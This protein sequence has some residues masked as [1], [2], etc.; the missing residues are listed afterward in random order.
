[1]QL[2]S[3]HNQQNTLKLVSPAAASPDDK[4]P[5]PQNSE[6]ITS[7]TNSPPQRTDGESKALTEADDE[8]GIKIPGIITSIYSYDFLFNFYQI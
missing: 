7:L 4:N 5:R 2:Q 3:S 8:N 6:N 1:M